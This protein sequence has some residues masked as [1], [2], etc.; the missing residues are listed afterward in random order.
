MR[1]KG[2]TLI[3][4]LVVVA[5]IAILAA[6][7]LPALSKARERARASVCMNNLKQIGVALQ[8]YMADYGEY[9]PP[10][11][12]RH[13][14]DV[15]DETDFRTNLPWSVTIA[16]YVGL[17][18]RRDRQWN[19]V[20][21]C[22]SHRITFTTNVNKNW[23]IGPRSYSVNL[24]VMG[25]LSFSLSGVPVGGLR[26]SRI[27]NPSNTIAVV[28]NHSNGYNS[29]G[30]QGEGYKYDNNNSSYAYTIQGASVED[31][32]GKRGY[33]HGGNNWLFV[34]GSVRWMNYVNTTNNPPG[35]APRSL[36]TP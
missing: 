14:V 19:T 21:K 8:M 12:Y 13:V 3:E 1:R 7:L 4:L 30:W 23:Y 33:H 22:P 15:N 28:E 20:F 31:D 34:D 32:P 9:L 10:A 35:T 29:I 26:L 6:M 17:D 18:I 2:F 11:Q 27:P 5:I 24:R 36:W 25:P 16:S